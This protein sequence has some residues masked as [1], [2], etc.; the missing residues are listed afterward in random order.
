MKR[1]LIFVVAAL[2][3]ALLLLPSTAFA[4]SI[5]PAKFSSTE[6]FAAFIMDY[7]RY[8]NSDLSLEGVRIPD[9]FYLLRQAPEGFALRQISYGPGSAGARF[10]YSPVALSKED[11]ERWDV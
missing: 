5:A 8:R 10:V 6:E 11:W 1:H 7:H 4:T 3:A 2:L 9:H